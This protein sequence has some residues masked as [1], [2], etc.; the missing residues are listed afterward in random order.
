MSRLLKA[1]VWCILF[2]A[3]LL[4]VVVEKLPYA[5]RVSRNTCERLIEDLNI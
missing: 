2:P 5:I 4:T 3:E 1:Y